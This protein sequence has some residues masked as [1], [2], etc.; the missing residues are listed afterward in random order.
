MPVEDLP[1]AAHEVRCSSASSVRRSYLYAVGV[2]AMWAA[3]ASP[4]DDWRDGSQHDGQ[5]LGPGA[6]AAAHL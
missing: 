6:R 5:R 3:P 1:E 4:G 2:L